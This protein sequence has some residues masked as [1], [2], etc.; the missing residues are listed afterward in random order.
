MAFKIKAVKNAEVKNIEAQIREASSAYYRGEPIMSDAQFDALEDQFRKQDPNNAWFEQVTRETAEYGKKIAHKY[1]LIG[2]VDKVHSIQ[3]SKLARSC[4]SVSISLK[5]DGSSMVVYY[6]DGKVH[7]ALTRGDGQYG[8]DVTSKYNKIVEKYNVTIPEHYTGAI[9]GEVIIS[10]ENWKKYK[11]LNPDAK[12]ARNVGTGLL[13]RKEISD[14]LLFVDWVV[15]DVIACSDITQLCS[16]IDA[17]NWNTLACFGYPLCP[18]VQDIC[19][20]KFS[21]QALKTLYE[22]WCLQYPAD[23]LVFEHRLDYSKQQDGS[24]V[25]SRENEAYKFPA[26][27]KETTV[28]NIEWNL[29]RTGKIVPTV[30]FES[31]PLS[32]ALVSRAS[33]YNYKFIKDIGIAVGCRINVRRSNE[34]IPEIRSVVDSAE[35]S[36]EIPSVCPVCGAQLSV[37]PTGVDLICTNPECQGG[38]YNRLSHYIKSMCKGIKGVGDVYIEHFVECM[39]CKHTIPELLTFVHGVLENPPYGDIVLERLGNAE[40]KLTYDSVLPALDITNINACNFLVA[41]GIPMFG[42]TYAKELAQDV[43]V[44]YNIIEAIK[45]DDVETV[46]HLFLSKFPGKIEVCNR[47]INSMPFVQDILNSDM[48]KQYGKISTNMGVNYRMY[49]VTGS[50]SKPRKEFE[51]ELQSKGWVLT[52]NINKAQLLINND[53]T[54]KSSKN[55]KAQKAGIPIISEEEFRQSYL[56]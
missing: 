7:C 15:Y 13:N 42:E 9:R 29:T 21:E 47:F 3:E 49:A 34:V 40:T 27:E 5:L 45:K 23:G 24:Y 14:D 46:R 50:V 30:V 48:F 33:G 35:S 4:T 28:T 41:L 18:H 22:K 56:F 2:S 8:I 39:A 10:Q 12:M 43:D 6:V 11:E 32:G 51:Q 25:I 31:I 38:A 55:V 36:I 17:E 20:S 54:S 53:K 19:L 16:S 52:D 1:I 44:L 26:E 37:T